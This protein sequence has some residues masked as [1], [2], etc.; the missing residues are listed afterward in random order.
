MARQEKLKTQKFFPAIWPSLSPH[1]IVYDALHKPPLW[2]KYLLNHEVQH[3]PPWSAASTSSAQLCL[4]LCDPVDCSTQG[5]PVH[6]QLPE[7]IQTHVHWVGDAIQPSHPLSSPSPSAFNFSQHQGLKNE[8]KAEALTVWLSLLG[9]AHHA[10]P[11]A[12]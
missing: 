12:C 6:H 2:Q 3:S 7:F 5:L 9:F 11:A 1:C 10:V 4:T 8:I